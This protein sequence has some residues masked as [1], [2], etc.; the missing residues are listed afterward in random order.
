MNWFF[1]RQRAKLL[2]EKE[3]AV[4]NSE[5]ALRQ[6][7][8]ALKFAMRQWQAANRELDRL[9]EGTQ[10]IDA[11]VGDLVDNLSGKSKR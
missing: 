6:S 11:T 1:R 4:L 3:E 8:N 9:L 10:N 7:K 5:Q 2:A